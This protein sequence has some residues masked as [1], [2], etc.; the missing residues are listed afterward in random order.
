MSECREDWS[1]RVCIFPGNARKCPIPPGGVGGMIWVSVELAGVGFG[2]I[3]AS[4][5]E[6]EYWRG[7]CV[8]CDFAAM[9]YT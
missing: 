4:P 9:M 5:L 8:G 2:N 7:I 3:F 6:I 1:H